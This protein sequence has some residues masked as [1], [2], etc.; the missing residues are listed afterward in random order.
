M[1]LDRNTNR[2]GRG[3]YAL[4]NMRK[5]I[6]RLDRVTSDPESKYDLAVDAFDLLVKEG[7]I[8]L[9]TESPGEQFF[10]MKYKDKFTA[11]GLQGYAHAVTAEANTLNDD[12]LAEYANQMYHEAKEAQK[13]GVRIPD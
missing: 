5:L 8:T 13:F 7:I 1:K 9:G 12:S 11:A 4:V 3:K 10:V 6:P 2:G